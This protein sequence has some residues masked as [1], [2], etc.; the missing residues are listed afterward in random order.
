M[1]FDILKASGAALLALVFAQG[2]TVLAGSLRRLSFQRKADRASFEILLTQLQAA[3]REKKKAEET[4]TS[5]SGIRKFSIKKKVVEADGICSLYLAPHDN[6]LLPSFNPGQY[7]TFEFDVPDQKKKV[8]RCYSLSDKARPDCYRV[9][10]KKIVP[11]GPETRG[12]L[13]STFVHEQLHENDIVDV[14]A[15]AGQF[16]LD[17]SQLTPVVLIGGGIGVTPVMAMLNEIVESGSKREVWFFYGMRNCSEY[18]MKEHLMAIAKAHDNVRLHICC[19]APEATDTDFHHKSRVGVDLFKTLLPSNN[20]NYY[21]CGPGPM[22]ESLITGLQE[23][24]VP[25]ENVH[26][27]AFGPASVKRTPVPKSEA[28]PTASTLKVTFVKS[29][30]SV[31]WDGQTANLLEL[32]EA[33]GIAMNFGCRAGNCGSCLTAVKSGEVT[34]VNEPGSKPDHGSCLTCICAPQ[35]ELVLDA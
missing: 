24:G 22:M 8:V 25:D 34:Y 23:W 20:F 29:G 17:T 18:V 2:A 19:S 28:P 1:D 33:N 15:P 9:T 11:S 30:K 6:K 7:L 35:T 26:F 32:A 3:R 12:G 10:I 16:F 21:I 31:T 14:R 27:E 13:V 4:G 5:W